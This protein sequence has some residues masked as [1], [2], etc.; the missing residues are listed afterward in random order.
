MQGPIFVFRLLHYTN[1][2]VSYLTLFRL[3][4][5]CP[6]RYSLL[7]H[8]RSSPFV[9]REHIHC[10]PAVSRSTSLGVSLFVKRRCFATPEMPFRDYV[11]TDFVLFSLNSGQGS[12]MEDLWLSVNWVPL[13]NEP[14]RKLCCVPR[15]FAT[16]SSSLLVGTSSVEVLHSS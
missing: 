14:E 16:Y 15:L 3:S 7:F 1:L 2:R 8:G 6:L 4:I 5:P 10:A 11:L 9:L 13:L 12:D